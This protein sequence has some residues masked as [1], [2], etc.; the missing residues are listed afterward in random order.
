M[1]I[2]PNAIFFELCCG[3]VDQNIPLQL[4]KSTFKKVEQNIENLAL[5]LLPSGRPFSKVEKIGFIAQY[6]LE[7]Q[8]ETN[9]LIPMSTIQK[10]VLPLFCQ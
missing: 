10:F 6:L 9:T 5:L 1:V 3:F 8:K 7:V 2:V 4:L